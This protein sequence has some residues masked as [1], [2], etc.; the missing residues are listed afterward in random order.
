MKHLQEVTD[1]DVPNHTYI[2]N[3]SKDRLLGYIPKGQTEP[4]MFTKPLKFETRHR[5]FKTIKEDK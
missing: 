3:D 4:M 2:V 5:K 1:W